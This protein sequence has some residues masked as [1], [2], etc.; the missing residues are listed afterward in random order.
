MGSSSLNHT[1]SFPSSSSV[2]RSPF[3]VPSSNDPIKLLL[4]TESITALDRAMTDETEAPSGEGTACQLCLCTA[5]GEDACSCG[6]SGECGEDGVGDRRGSAAVGDGAVP[7][8]VSAWPLAMRTR[9]ARL[10]GT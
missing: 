9:E 4:V 5:P 10:V 6:V 7:A 2:P 3:S 8:A 1:H